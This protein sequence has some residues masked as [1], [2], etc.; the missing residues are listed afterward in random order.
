MTPL[1]AA[2]SKS[3]QQDRHSVTN[4]LHW[5]F[6]DL[7]KLEELRNIQR[8]EGDYLEFIE[9]NGATGRT[10][11]LLRSIIDSREIEIRALRANGRFPSPQS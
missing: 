6:P 9:R 8:E 2:S 5:K 1:S 3:K 7:K 10:V 4:I 11:E